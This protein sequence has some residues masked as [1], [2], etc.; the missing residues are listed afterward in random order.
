[1][2]DLISMSWPGSVPAT[3]SEKKL[4]DKLNDMTGCITA[5]FVGQT[6]QGVSQGSIQRGEEMLQSAVNLGVIDRESTENWL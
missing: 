6:V 1:M 4:L 2:S 3:P 5:T